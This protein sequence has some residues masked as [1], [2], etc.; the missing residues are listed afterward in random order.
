MTMKSQAWQLDCALLSNVEVSRL[1]LADPK[2]VIEV[3]DEGA[4]TATAFIIATGG[5]PRTLSK[6]S[7]WA[8]CIAASQ[9]DA[10]EM[11]NAMDGAD[12]V[13][14][15]SWRTRRG[16]PGRKRNLRPGAFRVL[17]QYP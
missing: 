10:T 16:R 6:G 13:R 11:G 14:V 1:D 4:F 17:L 7:D 8:V 15:R 5:V 9:V 2:M 3:E 12:R